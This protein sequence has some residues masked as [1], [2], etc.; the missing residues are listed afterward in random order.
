MIEKKRNPAQTFGAS[1]SPDNVRGIAV[2]KY[3]FDV[4]ISETLY[5]T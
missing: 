5:I 1:M 2:N 3:V 4:I